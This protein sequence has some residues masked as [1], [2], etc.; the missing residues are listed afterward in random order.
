[1]RWLNGVNH[2]RRRTR[3]FVLYAPTGAYLRH[4]H[5]TYARAH[6]K[7]T[8]DLSDAWFTFDARTAHE[9]AVNTYTS[10][11]CLVLYE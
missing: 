2:N 10:V 11:Q 8:T 1:M 3:Y 5:W 6:E 4:R 7:Y 9:V